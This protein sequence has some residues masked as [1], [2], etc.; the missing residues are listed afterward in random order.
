MRSLND[1]LPLAG[2]K[3]HGPALAKREVLELMG[4]AA[5]DPVMGPLTLSRWPHLPD[6]SAAAPTSIRHPFPQPTSR[7][8]SP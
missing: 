8:T 1:N 7:K 5:T 3:L 6:A 2:K 4:S